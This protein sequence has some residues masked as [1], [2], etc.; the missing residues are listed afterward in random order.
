MFVEMFLTV[1][2]VDLIYVFWFSGP[3]PFFSL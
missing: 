3:D 2:K 1:F